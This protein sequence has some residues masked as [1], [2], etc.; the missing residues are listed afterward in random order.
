MGVNACRLG[1]PGSPGLPACAGGSRGPPRV[2]GVFCYE[3][4]L[5]A[6]QTCTMLSHYSYRVTYGEISRR[7]WGI[8]PIREDEAAYICARVRAGAIA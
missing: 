3:R 6:L 2:R 8:C 5:A 4:S 7:V 1:H